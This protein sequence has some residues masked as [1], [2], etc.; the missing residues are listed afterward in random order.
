MHA[1]LMLTDALLEHNLV[2]NV[3]FGL[4][5]IQKPLRCL[6][7]CVRINFDLLFIL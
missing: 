5:G 7:F 6:G 2:A 4:V 1:F 3:T